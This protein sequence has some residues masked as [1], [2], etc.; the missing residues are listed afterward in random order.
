M[1]AGRK[2]GDLA[3]GLDAGNL[4]AAPPKV[5][6]ADL[7]SDARLA[8]DLIRASVPSWIPTSLRRDASVPWYL[9]LLAL[10]LILFLFLLLP[11]AAAAGVGAAIA[12]A[13]IVIFRALRT[14]SQKVKALDAIRPENATP[15]SI[16]A[17]PPAS[18]FTITQPGSNATRTFGGSDSAEAA[19]FKTALREAYAPVMAAD[20]ASPIVVRTPI[21][22]PITAELS[23]AMLNPGRTI[24][25]RYHKLVTLPGHIRDGLVKTFDEPM[26]YPRID[27]PMYKP[28]AEMGP[29][30]FLP[31]VGR[32]EQNTIS[33]LE[34]NQKFIE[35]Y[36]VGLNHEFAR[37]LLWREYPTDQ[38]GTYFRQFWDVSSFKPAAGADPDAVREQLYDIPKLHNWGRTSKLGEHD[39]RETSGAVEDEAV[40]VIRGEL[41]KR[42]PTAVIYAHRAKWQMKNGDIDRS[43]P[44]LP[45]ELTDAEALTET[46]P[47]EK[48]KTPLYGAQVSPDIWF[49]GFDLTIT[50]A[51]GVDANDPGWFF[52]IKERPGEPRFGLDVNRPTTMPLLTWNDLAWNDAD[53]SSSG[54][55]LIS[56][57]HSLATPPTTEP[58]AE[59]DQHLEDVQVAWN[60]NT[61]A[62]D[63]AYVLYQLPVLVA[64]HA[65]E[66]LPNN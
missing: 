13:A 18:S 21:G 24:A 63:V 32:I 22:V 48:I 50:E 43:K 52:V 20:M 39:H 15:A 36:M 61:N 51:K 1:P 30:L 64:V 12:G 62:A 11:L 26:A 16:D 10:V 27:L 56:G 33:L 19:R 54:N 7:P 31:N 65:A 42:Y 2:L 29:D 23:I 44:R 55:L 4:V 8:D 41:L 14:A 34:T 6:A 49:F 5:L 58:Q 46:P 38:R 59:R 37:E 17:L 47:L 53:T 3:R 45:L 60:A 9:L 25:Q 57:S 35:S 28:L 40:L 66:M